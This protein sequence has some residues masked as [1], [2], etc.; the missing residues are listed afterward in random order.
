MTVRVDYTHVKLW[1]LHAAA[2]VAGITPAQLAEGLA[3][4]EIAGR[5]SIASKERLLESDAYVNGHRLQAWLDTPE[6]AAKI[7]EI[8][9]HDR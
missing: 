2:R 6:G 7:L 3:S 4:N 5:M 9:G 8:Q 1:R